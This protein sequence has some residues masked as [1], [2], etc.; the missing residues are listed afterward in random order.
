MLP[1]RLSID[2]Y[3][4]AWLNG[5]VTC[6]AIL[7]LSCGGLRLSCDGARYISILLA[8]CVFTDD[9]SNKCP[10]CECVDRIAKLLSTKIIL[11]PFVASTPY[12]MAFFPIEQVDGI[13]KRQRVAPRWINNIEPIVPMACRDSHSRNSHNHVGCHDFS[14]ASHWK[15]RLLCWSSICSWSVLLPSSRFGLINST[16]P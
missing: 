5:A 15:R 2:V 9:S 11:N 10:T 12:G 1:N 4:R 8:S 16:V 13:S 3:S 14:A 7:I 6:T